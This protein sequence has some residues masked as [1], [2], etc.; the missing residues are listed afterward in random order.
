VAF[1]GT[2]N[3]LGIVIY[4]NDNPGQ[5]EEVLT[6]VG[7]SGTSY[8]E[9]YYQQ[10]VGVPYDHA[11][12]TANGENV[13][14]SPYRR[15]VDIDWEYGGE[16]GATNR[17]PYVDNGIR[18][19]ENFDLRGAAPHIPQRQ[20]YGNYGDA[21]YS[22]SYTEWYSQAIAFGAQDEITAEESWAIVSGGI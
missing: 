5:T 15:A 1:I 13:R 14:P 16:P 7:P 12:D 19:W 6:G 22:D 17:A 2:P 10:V 20:V 11:R 3:E 4:E 9:G 21:G 8:D 18:R